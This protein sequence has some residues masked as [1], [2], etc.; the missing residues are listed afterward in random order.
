VVIRNLGQGAFKNPR[1]FDFK[2]LVAIT[3]LLW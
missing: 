3:I 2:E 1:K